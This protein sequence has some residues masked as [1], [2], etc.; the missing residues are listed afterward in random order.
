[1]KNLIAQLTTD[2]HSEQVPQTYCI[3]INTLTGV[4]CSQLM[5]HI[6]ATRRGEYT[7]DT[8]TLDTRNEADE[9]TRGLAV[10]NFVTESS[11][12]EVA[13]TPYKIAQICDGIRHTMYEELHTYGE[14]N[15]SSALI[16][17]PVAHLGAK[18][19]FNQPMSA[20]MYMDFRIKNA[21]RVNDSEIKLASARMQLPEDII[22]QALTAEAIRNKLQLTRVAPDVLTEVA[23]LDDAFDIDAFTALDTI[24][25]GNIAEKISAKFDQAYMRLLPA[26]IRS[27]DRASDLN[28][29]ALQHAIVKTW[30]TENDKELHTAKA[31]QQ[32]LLKA[33]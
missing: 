32:E 6:H 21:D 15:D 31:H 20:Q 12:F 17:T 22:R 23:S 24:V 16:R 5:R 9:A 27:L 33:A 3:I 10:A 4:V 28:A 7:D 25:Q 13:M 18:V 2:L 30:L 1:M 8:S 11:G 29:L 14:F 19:N 26:A